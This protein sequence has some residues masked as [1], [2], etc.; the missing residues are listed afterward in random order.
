MA[1]GVIPP[2][3]AA[4]PILT[5]V[6][7]YVS[8]IA[9]N[10]PEEAIQ[11]VRRVNPFPSVCGRI[12]TRQ[13]QTRCRRGQIDEPI[14]IAALKRF[15]ADTQGNAD[16]VSAA[17]HIY[18]ERIAVVGSGPSGLAAAHDL[19][20]L[21]YKVTVF[22]ARSVLGGLL[23]EGIPEYR[24]PRDVVQEEI[25]RVLSLGIEAKAGQSL[26]RDFSVEGLM[27]EYQAVFIALGSQKSL[28]PKCRGIGMKG[29]L[30]GVEFLKQVSRGQVSSIGSSVVVIGGG[31]TAI[32]AA[33]TSIRL[34]AGEVTLVYR[35]TLREMPARSEVMEAEKEGVKFMFLASPVVFE[36]N[37]R[38]EK[39]RCVK[40][41]LGE[42]DDSGRCRPTPVDNS[43]FE[44]DA[45]TIILAIGYAPDAE[46]L[47]DSGLVLNR[48]GTVIANS[49]TGITNL[50]GVFAAG[51]V[52]SGPLSVIDAIASG[53]RVAMAIHRYLRG[54]PQ[55]QDEVIPVLS[56]LD[57]KTS[58]LIGKTS[59]EEMPK[60]PVIERIHS[61][62]EVELGYT[63]EQAIREAQ[64]C[65]N[66]GSGAAVDDKCAACLNCVR[67]CPYGIPEPGKERAEIDINQCQ[68]CG[69]CASECPASAIQLQ[70]DTPEAF[71]AQLADI[72]NVSLQGNPEMLIVGFYCLYGSMSM[73]PND[74]E[75]I[76][77]L[78]KPCTGRLNEF[79]LIAPFEYGADGV[80]VHVCRDGECRFRA[81][82]QWAARHVERARKILDNTGI[83][84]ERLC[85]FDSGECI[86]DFKNR[87][88][89]F[90]MNP[91][92]KGRQVNL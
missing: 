80:A 77:W 55:K 12:C 42:P 54:F 1:A 15:A 87:L 13:C 57:A 39:V 18:K 63:T 41:C 30:S 43:E 66:C 31:H 10:R 46:T 91:I 35:R 69:I 33:R 88:Y 40:M 3:Q 71:H 38:I 37:Q 78:G 16:I 60:L 11:I 84:G 81:G 85:V 22:E 82:Q 89:A 67:I 32:D 76:F 8:A 44:I 19:A 64:R 34:G 17:R 26:G 90:G 5:D 58:G 53:K 62:A 28:L 50:E 14:S 45:D 68:A 36:G 70:L 72:I 65:L 51:D 9:R 74:S 4:C 92:R 52:V 49:I 86:P 6:R 21:G 48:D 24:L 56:P 27:K 25:R 73:P 29:I 79:Q 83:G 2:C 61:F 23:S 47:K 20:I 75:G 7:G 59:R